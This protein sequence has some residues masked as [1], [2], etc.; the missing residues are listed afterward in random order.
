MRVVVGKEPDDRDTLRGHLETGPLEIPQH[1]PCAIAVVV[2]FD[3]LRGPRYH[4]QQRSKN[5]S[6]LQDWLQV[7]RIPLRTR[8]AILLERRGGRGRF[9]GP[10]TGSG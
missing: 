7:S 10:R 1:P 8:S 3:C 6:N 2:S 5:I 4:E 9:T